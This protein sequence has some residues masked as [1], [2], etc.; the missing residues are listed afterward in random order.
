MLQ[1]AKG[2]CITLSEKAVILCLWSVVRLIVPACVW[3]WGS[4]FLDTAPWPV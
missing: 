3:I 1:P 2:A 4:C